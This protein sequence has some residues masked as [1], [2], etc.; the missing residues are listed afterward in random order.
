MN[1]QE[2][3]QEKNNEDI[4]SKSGIFA[5]EMIVKEKEFYKDSYLKQIGILFFMLLSLFSGLYYVYYANFLYEPPVSYVVIDE[6]ERILKQYPLDKLHVKKE[7]M[8]QW[9]SNAVLDIFSY[10]YLTFET[11]GKTVSK[12]YSQN[13]QFD[14]FMKEFNALSLQQIVK[15]Q[16]AIIVPNFKKQ[17]E[18]AEQGKIGKNKIAFSLKGEIKLEMHGSEGIKVIVRKI[19][20][21]V[22]RENFEINKDGF[23]IME[24]V[25]EDTE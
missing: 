6:N 3:E 9:V 19:K 16:K 25:L 21:V 10:N 20:V 5:A 1:D 12:Y 8:V 24:I 22:Y 2:I 17:L 15:N 18:V 13:N 14:K 4:L 11:H 7:D 23:A